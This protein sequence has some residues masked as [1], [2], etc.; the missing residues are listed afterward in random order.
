LLNACEREAPAFPVSI[1]GP[2]VGTLIAEG[3][4][5]KEFDG[6]TYILERGIQADV[7]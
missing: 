3:K 2:E 7:A 6:I 1:R 5:H 4:E